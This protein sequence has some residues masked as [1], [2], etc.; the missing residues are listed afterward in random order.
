M[1]MVFPDLDVVAV[2]TAR[3]NHNF[4]EFAG[5]ISRSVKSDTALPADAASAKLLADKIC[6]VSTEK[7]TEVGP[8]PKLAA[9]ISGKIYR[10]PPN[11][12]NVKS[13]SLILVDPQPHYKIEAYARDVPIAP[14]T[15]RAAIFAP[16]IAAPITI[17]IERWSAGLG[18]GVNG[19]QSLA[20]TIIVSTN[21]GDAMRS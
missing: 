9:T 18:P 10:F 17:P 16:I 21:E 11:E 15:V 20:D 19:I 6:D 7:P 2:T 5:F 13:L 1:V 3:D 4:G 12:I 8:D 14:V